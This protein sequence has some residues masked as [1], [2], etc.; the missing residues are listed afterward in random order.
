MARSTSVAKSLPF[1][2]T[3]E[4]ARCP[5]MNGADASSRISAAVPSSA[6]SRLESIGSAADRG[7]GL[8]KG[9]SPGVERLSD[10]RTLD[11]TFG[12]GGDGPQIIEAR[13]AAGGDDGDTAAFGDRGEQLQIRPGQGAV[14][15]D[16]GDHIPG[17]PLTLK[18]VQHLPQ[19]A[20]VGLPAA[21]AE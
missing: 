5:A 12:Q 11:A 15:G 2:R 16:V 6:A 4:S 7:Q 9:E 10:D 18:A 14:L 21:T 19:I 13:H 17:T 1:L 20:P 8:G 3:A